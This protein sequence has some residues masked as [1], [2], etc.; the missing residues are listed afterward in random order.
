MFEKYLLWIKTFTVFGLFV[1]LNIQK[2]EFWL[3]VNFGTH[4]KSV[5]RVLWNHLRR[6]LARTKIKKTKPTGDP[7]LYLSQTHSDACVISLCYVSLLSFH[8]KSLGPFILWLPLYMY[9][10]SNEKNPLKAY[11]A[12]NTT[13]FCVTTPFVSL[14]NRIHYFKILCR[15]LSYRHKNCAYGACICTHLCEV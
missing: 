2:L 6:E 8:S 11:P 9:K 1:T 12:F 7:D 13:A 4:G 14:Y 3:L 10:V 5:T 15:Y